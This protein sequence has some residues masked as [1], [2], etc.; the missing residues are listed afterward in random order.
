MSA[1]NI[2]ISLVV[3]LVALVGYAFIAQNMTQRRQKKTR[4]LASLKARANNF[5]FILNRVPGGY[6]PKDLTLL[7]QRGLER[8]Y[9]QLHDLEPSE[10]AHKDALSR[11]R[12][13]MAA[14]V[15]QNPVETVVCLETIQ[16]VKEIKTC[17]EELYQYVFQMEHKKAL[18]GPQASAYRLLI[19]QLVMVLK[20]DSYAI[21]GQDA[22]SKG[23]S[24]LAAHWFELGIELL[25]GASDRG[26]FD[27]RIAKL[28]ADVTRLAPEQPSDSLT[29]GACA[30][31]AD[32]TD[33]DDLE[34]Q[35]LENIS[36]EWKKNQVYD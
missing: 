11:L 2:I 17:L 20:A 13:G 24:K 33:A 1:L 6:F 29:P 32:K 19:Q 35:E 9:G 22:K 23:K 12:Q 21:Y 28:K 8:S 30:P 26:Q 18:S 36:K 10:S 25:E 14:T 5:Q 15:R 31:T 3:L 7:I 16:D 34:W 27:H 4:L